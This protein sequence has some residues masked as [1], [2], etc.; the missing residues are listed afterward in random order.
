MERFDY[1]VLTSEETPQ[2]PFWVSSAG[3]RL[4]INLPAILTQ[5]GNQ[6]WEM[7]GAA[8]VTR[9][10]RPEIFFKKRRVGA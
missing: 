5:L 3:Q 9:T 1:L 4:G 8:D 6:G 10:A 7:I 2:G